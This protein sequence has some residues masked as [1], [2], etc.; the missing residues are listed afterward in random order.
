MNQ[1][2]FHFAFGVYGIIAISNKL[3]VIR[4]NEGPYINR[5]DL[6]G[7]S[8][9]EGEPLRHAVSRELEEET[10][11]K[12]LNAK[13][14]GTVSFRY[15]WQYQNYNWNEHVC[16]F[17]HVDE[18][19]GVPLTDVNQFVGQDSLGANWIDIESINLENSSPLVLKAKEF[20]LLKKFITTDTKYDHWN[21]LN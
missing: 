12:I 15:P 9:Q 17:Y 4:K 21:V 19:S 14:L 20:V 13:Q 10:G 7:G 8:L 11:L 2:K 18:Y 3:L 6:P 5:Y 1:K 16:V